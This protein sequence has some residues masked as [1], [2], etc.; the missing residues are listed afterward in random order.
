MKNGLIRAQKE[1]LKTRAV[2]RVNTKALLNKMKQ[3]RVLDSDASKMK[4]VNRNS[5]PKMQKY[6]NV[7][8]K[9]R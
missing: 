3:I 9:R 1:R 7:D 5:D 2:E 8:P 6:Y 4:R